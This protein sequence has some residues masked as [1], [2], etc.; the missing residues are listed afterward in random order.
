M[1]PIDISSFRLLYIAA[2]PVLLFALFPLLATR[3]SHAENGMYLSPVAIA[4]DRDGKTLYVAGT[5]ARSVAVF[6]CT[7]EKV[8]RVIALKKQPGGACPVS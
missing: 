5:T 2:I 1:K 4:A 3:G 8:T 6:D 7:S